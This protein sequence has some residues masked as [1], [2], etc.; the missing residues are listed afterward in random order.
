MAGF[1]LGAQLVDSGEFLFVDEVD[2]AA[3]QGLDT[4]FFCLLKEARQ[5]VE[6]TVVSD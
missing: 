5:A 6:H 4:V 3:E 2:F 1:L